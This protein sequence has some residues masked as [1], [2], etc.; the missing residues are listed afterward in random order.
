MPRP[1]RWH[2][3]ANVIYLL[4]GLAAFVAVLFIRVC[5]TAE[6]FFD[7]WNVPQPLKAAIGMGLMAAG[8]VAR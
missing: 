4:L 2:T 6:G 3:R 7:G 5:S 1:I 8:V